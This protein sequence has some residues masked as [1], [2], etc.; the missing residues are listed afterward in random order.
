MRLPAYYCPHCKRFKRNNF[1]DRIN[2]EYRT[3]CRGCLTDLISTETELQNMLENFIENKTT[4][5]GQNK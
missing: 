5:K 2:G 3:Y 4:E 1:L